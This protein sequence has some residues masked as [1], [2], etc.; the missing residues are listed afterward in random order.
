MAPPRRGVCQL[1]I[2][3]L[4]SGMTQT[5]LSLRTGIS[6]RMISYYANN[7]KRMNVDAAKAISTA[8]NCSIEDLYKW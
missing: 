3:L 6:Q 4:K 2:L 1:D 8:L 5:Q 7:K